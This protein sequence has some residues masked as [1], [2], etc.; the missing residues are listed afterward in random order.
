M[1]CAIALTSEARDRV[2]RH[3]ASLRQL[4]PDA[5]AS[6][7]RPENIHLTLKFLGDI[8]PASVSDLSDAAKRAVAKLEGFTIRVEQA[9]FFP[10]RGAPRV[11]WLGINDEE[12]QLA[13]L[14]DRLEVECA[15][16]GFPRE[17]RPFR[18]HL[19]I[20][21]LRQASHAAT[22]AST[23]LQMDFAPVEVAISA[24]LVIRSELSSS[25]SK[26]TV[27]SAA[28]LG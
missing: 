8:S 28:S 3:V 1:F 4:V 27:I 17:N 22:L 20:A 14:H 25:G 15:K 21:R 11:L 10:P 16:A 19:T 6:W 12:A 9:G 24:L 23:H 2:A 13:Q 18:P 26:Y 5:R 7:T